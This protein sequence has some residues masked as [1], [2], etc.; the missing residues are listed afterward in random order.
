MEG[1]GGGCVTGW[2]AGGCVTPHQQPRWFLWVSGLACKTEPPLPRLPVPSPPS[3]ITP[4]AGKLSEGLFS[5]MGS[6]NS[7]LF[8]LAAVLFPAEEVRGPEDWGGAS[9][10]T[11]V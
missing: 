1:D 3:S 9:G 7:P 6:E 10:A 2:S 8:V 5:R 11:C 4:S